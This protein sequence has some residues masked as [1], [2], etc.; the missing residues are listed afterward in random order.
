MGLPVRQRRVLERIEL[1]LQRSD[2][3]LASLY[4]IFARL[5]RDEEMPRIEQVRHRMLLILIRVRLLLSGLGSR[6]PFR[7]VPRQPAM[8]FFP[9]AV[10]I[11]VTSVVFAVKTGHGASTCSP[12]RTV[13]AS[14]YVIRTPLCR[15]QPFLGH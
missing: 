1:R 4:A 12:T 5:N 3:K 6:F 9:L 8:L 7:L 10:A 14:R 11:L 13:A 15:P 2:P